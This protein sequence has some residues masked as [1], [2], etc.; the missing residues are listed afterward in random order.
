MADEKYEPHVDPVPPPTG[1]WAV[2]KFITDWATSYFWLPLTFLLIWLFSKGAKLI[3]GREPQEN[4]DYLIGIAGKMVQGVCII[5]VMEVMRQQTG[6]WWKQEDLKT[7]PHLA[8][9]QAA[10]QCVTITALVWLFLH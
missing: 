5:F 1:W 7:Y 8:Y 3:T 9:A 6:H 10:T 4:V 2:W